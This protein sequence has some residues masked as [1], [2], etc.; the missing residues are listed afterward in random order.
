MT[1]ISGERI[2]MIH[3]RN[4]SG[5]LALSA[6][7]LLVG[8]HAHAQSAPPSVSDSTTMAV[9]AG[10]LLDVARGKYR[11]NVV[12][13]VRNGRITSIVPA[14]SFRR[15]G[16]RMVDLSRSTVM[17]GLIDGHVHLAL[18][19]NRHENAIA[20]LTAG[21]TTIVDLGDVGFRV[22]QLRDSITAGTAVGPR[23]LAAGRWVG[24]SGGICDFNKIG[25]VGDSTAYS[26]AVNQNI[27]AGA[28]VIKVCISKWLPDA[29]A[30]PD[31]Y[32]LP[33]A[34]IRSVV[35]S[36]HTERRRVIAHD[37]SSG[38]VRAAVRAGVDG[39]AHGALVDR[40][41]AKEMKAKGMFLMPTLASLTSGSPGSPAEMAL[42][43]SVRIA[44]D[45][46]VL[47]VFGTDA[48]VLPHGS[49][50]QEF[51]ALVRAGLSPLEV[52]RSATVNAAMA[53]GISAE[54]GTI[55]VGRP[56]DLIAVDGD[57]LRDVTILQRVRFVMRSGR[58]HVIG[59]HPSLGWNHPRLPHVVSVQVSVASG[60]HRTSGRRAQGI[61]RPVISK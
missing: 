7:A 41:L 59:Y 17:P 48:G 50:A 28:D 21:F 46:G 13:L 18:Q 10:R 56:A 55:A 47:I 33:D 49:N 6:L 1:L 5:L 20:T 14:K 40:A 37:L 26:V 29:Y 12:I 60:H 8:E 42:A 27:A 57:P 36:A 16:E 51:G 54:A 4:V 58:I 45:A 22:I 31:A 53:L 19:G 35:K 34:A 9:S 44:K 38:G 52:I 30:S 25:V 39:L 2:R 11:S 15:R 61:S 43:E 24:A 23:I 3:M 32:E